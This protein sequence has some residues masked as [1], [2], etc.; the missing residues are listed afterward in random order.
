VRTN[1]EANIDKA[2]IEADK[3]KTEKLT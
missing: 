2:N 1:R 3:A